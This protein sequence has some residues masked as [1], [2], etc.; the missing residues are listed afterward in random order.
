MKGFWFWLAVTLA[1]LV[2]VDDGAPFIR[3]DN[4]APDVTTFCVDGQRC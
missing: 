1:T 2:V 3:H 4:P